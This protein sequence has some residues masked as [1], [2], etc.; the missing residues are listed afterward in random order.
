MV[1]SIIHSIVYG[2]NELSSAVVRKL[3][4]A[5][6]TKL[7]S[8]VTRKLS[9]AVTTKLSHC[10]RMLNREILVSDPPTD[11]QTDATQVQVLSCA[12]AAK[13]NSKVKSS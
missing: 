2:I 9:S 10:G 4:S 3:S 1:Y 8:A 12:F 11:I 7:S 6:I 13:N 5:A